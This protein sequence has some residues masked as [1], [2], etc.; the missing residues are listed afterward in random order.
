MRDKQNALIEV[1][2]P[3]SAFCLA[4][5]DPRFLL[6]LTSRLK[7]LYASY[8]EPVSCYNN[9]FIGNSS[10]PT[11]RGMTVLLPI[12]QHILSLIEYHLKVLMFVRF[13]KVWEK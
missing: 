2:K 7:N 11:H 4:C 1:K 3:M 13:P 10:L 9:L 8:T 6:A 5:L 12:R